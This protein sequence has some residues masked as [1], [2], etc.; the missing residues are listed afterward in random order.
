MPVEEIYLDF[1]P[2]RVKEIDI[3]ELNVTF[4]CV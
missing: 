2:G 4:Y 1:R 3:T